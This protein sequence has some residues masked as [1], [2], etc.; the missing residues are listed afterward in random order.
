M[1]AKYAVAVTNG[2]A[3]LAPVRAGPGRAAG[4]ARHHDSYHLRRLGQLRALLRRR[5]AFR[6]H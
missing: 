2:T 6:R 3:A 1:G 4:A 5:G